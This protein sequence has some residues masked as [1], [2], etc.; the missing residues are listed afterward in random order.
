[1]LLSLRTEPGW[2]FSSRWD[3]RGVGSTFIWHS[4]KKIIDI[5]DYLLNL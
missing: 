3:H 5:I 4:K 2:M 1:M